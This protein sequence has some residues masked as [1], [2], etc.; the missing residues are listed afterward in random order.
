M[1]LEI[2]MYIELINRSF[3]WYSANIIETIYNRVD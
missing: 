2:D 1:D 3:D